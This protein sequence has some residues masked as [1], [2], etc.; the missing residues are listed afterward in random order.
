MDIHTVSLHF[1]LLSLTVYSQHCT[2][3][4]NGNTILD[5]C[6][7]CREVTVGG[8]L[9]A[10]HEKCGVHRYSPVDVDFENIPLLHKECI[11]FT[12]PNVRASQIPKLLASFDQV[13]L[14]LLVTWVVA[15][16]TGSKLSIGFDPRNFATRKK[17]P[18]SP[19]LTLPS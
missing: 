4:N 15:E 5:F 7:L 1:L 10:F 12:V 17:I 16:R 14:D 18:A 6:P 19:N 11:P 3:V 8:S 2:Y 13:F 9:A